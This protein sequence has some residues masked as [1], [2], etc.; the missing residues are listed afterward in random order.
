MRFAKSGP[1]EYVVGGENGRV[2]DDDAASSV[3]VW[4]GATCADGA[5]TT[6]DFTGAGTEGEGARAQDGFNEEEPRCAS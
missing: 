5:A 2:V 4:R 3:F 1:N 6:F